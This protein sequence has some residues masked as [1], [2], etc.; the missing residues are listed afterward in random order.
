LRE[1]GARVPFIAYWDGVTPE[2]TAIDDLIDFT[3]IYPTLLQVAGVK[4][5]EGLSGVSFAP[6]LHGRKGTPRTS[7]Y[8]HLN[9]EG[10][11]RFRTRKIYTD[12]RL[13]DMSKAPYVE[14]CDE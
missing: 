6:Q 14:K 11:T 10:Y 4:Q 7:V 13:C 3:D 1:G 5:I 9:D 12:G 8:V 2:N